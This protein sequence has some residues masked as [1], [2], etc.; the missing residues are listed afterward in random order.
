MYKIHYIATKNS[1]D[2]NSELREKK[3]SD[4]YLQVRTIIC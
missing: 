3:L 2:C 4:C 1:K